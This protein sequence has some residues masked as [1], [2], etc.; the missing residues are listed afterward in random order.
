MPYFSEY[1]YNLSITFWI[2]KFELE[3]CKFMRAENYP[4]ILT[5]PKSQILTGGGGGENRE[6][7]DRNIL[8]AFLE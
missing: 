7:K 3:H 6:E 4:S 1:R 5:V 8:A 2:Q